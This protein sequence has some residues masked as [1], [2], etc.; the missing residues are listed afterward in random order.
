[1]VFTQ[2]SSE[3]EKLINKDLDLPSRFIAES[4]GFKDFD[5]ASINS[6][7]DMKTIGWK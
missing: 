2:S 7:L 4:L 1:M 3:T 6:L 5:Y